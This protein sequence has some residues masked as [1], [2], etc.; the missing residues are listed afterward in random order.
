MAEPLY[1]ANVLIC[2]GTEC[3]ASGSA[4]VLGALNQEVDRRNLSREIRVVQTD[5]R[6]FCAVGPVLIIYPEGI[7]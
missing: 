4:E 2:G 6:G 7:L 1:R 5:C 3:Q